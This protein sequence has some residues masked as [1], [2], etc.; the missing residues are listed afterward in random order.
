MTFPKT[1]VDLKALDEIS[2]RIAAGDGDRNEAD[3][4]D[5]YE[6]NVVVDGFSYAVKCVWPDG[7]EAHEAELECSALNL[8]P[9]ATATVECYRD[10]F[11][12][13][14][15]DWDSDWWSEAWAIDRYPGTYPEYLAA[16]Q[17]VWEA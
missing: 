3:T 17:K 7:S 14:G 11:P 13:A 4:A 15:P 12:G 16:C 10:D 5:T 9:F 6:G 8:E 2:R 1:S